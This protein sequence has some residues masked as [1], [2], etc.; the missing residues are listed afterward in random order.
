MSATNT[1]K[2][3]ASVAGA[4]AV[5][6]P[7]DNSAAAELALMRERFAEMERQLAAMRDKADAAAAAPVVEREPDPI[8]HG[9]VLACG[10]IAEAPNP[11]AS[12]HWCEEHAMTVPVKS[13][14]ELRD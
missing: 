4:H 2:G 1:I 6:E 13:A 3:S 8:T 7:E 5:T 12:H 9:L 14:F 11:H 10:H